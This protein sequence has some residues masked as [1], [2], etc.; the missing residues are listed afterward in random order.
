MRRDMLGFMRQLHR[1]YGDLVEFRAAGRRIALVSA[2][3]LIERILVREPQR[4]TKSRVLT[5]YTSRQILGDGL[6]VSVGERHRR[7]R[8]LMQPAFRPPGI[9]QQAEIIARWARRWSQRWRPGQRVIMAQ[10]MRRLTLGIAA[11]AFFGGDLLEEADELSEALASTLALFPR[12]T[13]PLADWVALLPLPSNRRF[14]RARDRLETTVHRL[15]ERRRRRPEDRADVL[16]LLLEAEAERGDVDGRS[17]RDEVMTLLIAGHET[18]ALALSWT[19]YLLS[20]HPATERR[21]RNELEAEL[22]DRTPG[23]EDIE[24]LTYTRWVLAESMRMF[25]PAFFVEREPREDFVLDGHRIPAGTQILMS[26]YLVHRDPRWYREPERFR[27]ERWGEPGTE[28]MPR[29]SYFPFGGG[30]RTCIGEGFA[31]TEA[32]LVLATLARSWRAVPCGTQPVA[33]EPLVTLQPR[34]G[35]P[36]QPKRVCAAR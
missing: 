15:I 4:F 11:E 28:A 34:D 35:L 22:G 13:V 7:R 10:E 12:M 19:W 31:W 16:S 33:P 30:P 9:A 21:L 25:P 32:T 24:R 17:V 18:T 2:P 27:P 14:W 1:D 8:R 29:F 6:L 3:E 36:M 5:M 23:Y 20:Q 26:Q